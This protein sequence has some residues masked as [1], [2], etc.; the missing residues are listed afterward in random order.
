MKKHTIEQT[1]IF[2][3]VAKWLLLSSFIGIIIGATVTLFLNILQFSEN[4]QHVVGF[5]HYYLLPFGLVTTVWLVKTFA[6]D[7]QGHGTEKVIEAVHKKSGKIEIAVIP[8]KLLTTVVTI[9]TGGSVGKEGPGAQIGAGMASFISDL[10]HFSKEDRKK[11]VICGIGAGFA[12]VFGTP[13]AGAIF[14]VEVLIVGLIRYDVLLPSFIAG[15]AAFSTAQYLGIDYTYFD[16]NFHQTV[17]LNLPLILKVI[18]AGL[19]FGLISDITI[20]FLKR[21]ERAITKIPLNV[22]IKAFGG[23]LFLVG[24][25]FVFGDEYFGLGIETIDQ[26]LRPDATLNANIPWYAFILKTIFTAI[27]LGSGGSGGIVTPIFYIGATSGNLFGTLMGD[28]ITFF[29][30]IGFVSVL[31]GTTNAPIA[32]TIMAMELFGIEV[33]H[34]AAI[35]VVISFFMTGHRSVFPSQILAMS[36]SDMLDIKHGEIIGNADVKMNTAEID[37]LKNF[38]ERLQNKRKKR[39]EPHNSKK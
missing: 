22:Y 38:R 7:A 25:S 1:T 4:N 21:I 11:L 30:A 36:K 6:P 13:I 24:L 9:F 20:T 35:S 31:A 27:T 5:P 3:S 26:A 28:H 12:S 10:F 15:F 19:F 32:A 29:A 39:N 16:I 14:G 23:G 37:R 8:I 18:L 17:T 2:F 34:Y 33:A